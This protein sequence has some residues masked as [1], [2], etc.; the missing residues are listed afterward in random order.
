MKDPIGVKKKIPFA[1]AIE[2][3]D[4]LLGDSSGDRKPRVAGTRGWYDNANDRVNFI[5]PIFVTLIFV[6]IQI[7]VLRTKR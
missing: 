6:T 5:I 4:A 1:F 3:L 7:I 2:E